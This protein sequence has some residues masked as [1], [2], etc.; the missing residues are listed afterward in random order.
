MKQHGFG[1]CSTCWF[2]LPVTCAIAALRWRRSTTPRAQNLLVHA[3]KAVRVPAASVAV[4][5]VA[6]A[7]AVLVVALL[8]FL[9]LREANVEADCDQPLRHFKD[10]RRNKHRRYRAR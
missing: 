10:R 3:L 8:V 2:E 7:V 6:I 1:R 9:A 4:M 5:E